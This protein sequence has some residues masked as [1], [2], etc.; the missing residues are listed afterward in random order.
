LQIG[1]EHIHM[2]VEPLLDITV[3]E[4][5]TRRETQVVARRLG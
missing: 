1:L 4:Q 5:F 2:N 3:A